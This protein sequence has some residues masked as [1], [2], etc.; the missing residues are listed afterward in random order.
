MASRHPRSARIERARY[1]GTPLRLAEVC[2]MV[3]P[4]VES[5]GRTLQTGWQLFW[6]GVASTVA[7]TVLGTVAVSVLGKLAGAWPTI[8]SGITYP[9]QVPAVVLVLGLSL[10]LV[11]LAFLLYLQVRTHA[12]AAQAL[13]IFDARGAPAP[14]AP[15]SDNENKVV[16]VLAAADGKH[17][18]L[19]QIAERARLS[20]LLTQQAISSL[21]GRDF[22]NDSLAMGGALFFLS[23]KGV[24]YA[25]SKGYVRQTQVM[26][27]PR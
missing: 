4:G 15:M 27:K 24:D 20:N 22:V 8:R 13:A 5:R 7:G 17:L 16:A 25:V 21:S 11:A 2:A 18:Y 14:V 9:I 19:A 6:V 12:A 10:L 1:R 26:E 3:C 23:A